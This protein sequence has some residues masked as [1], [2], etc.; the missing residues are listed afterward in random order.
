MVR[1]LYHLTP[2]TRSSL[3]VT[4]TAFR[5]KQPGQSTLPIDFVIVGGAVSGLAA[6]IALSRAGHTVT[7]FEARPAGG[8]R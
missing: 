8:V 7:L 5:K 3:N 4:L 1:R 6:A 2:S